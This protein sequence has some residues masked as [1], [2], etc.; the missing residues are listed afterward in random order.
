MNARYAVFF[1]PDDASDLAAYG[2][3][4]LGRTADG[5]PV[6]PSIGDYPDRPMSAE[7]SETPAHYGFHATLKAPFV[8]SSET[9]EE[10][11]LA[12]VERFAG[13]QAPVVMHSLQPCLLSEFVALGFAS[14]PDA[15]ARLAGQ[16]VEQFEAFRAPLSDEDLRKRKP[17]QLSEAQKAYLF[18][19]GYPFVMSE[20]R[21]HMT[22]TGRVHST[23]HADYIKWLESTYRQLVPTAPVLDRVAVFWQPDR[24]TPFTR[25]AQYVF[26]R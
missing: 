6:N 24:Q 8:L 19:Y 23:E 16:C 9:S 21:F 22:L 26:P 7:L 25:L 14:Q 2:Q 18:K 12:A 20:F 1:S 4:V 13:H 15:V 17:E 3:Q 5:H 10:Q 11:L